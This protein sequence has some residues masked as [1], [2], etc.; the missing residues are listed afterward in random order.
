MHGVYPRQWKIFNWTPL[1]KKGSK[2]NR[3]NYRPISLLNNLAKILDKIV[4]K[5]LYN[6]CDK[7]KYLNKYNYGFKQKTSCQHNLAMLLHNTYKILDKGNEALII[8]FDVVKAFDKVDH[9]ILL[10][11]LYMLGINNT[12]HNWF[13]NYL[14]NRFSSVVINNYKSKKY[15][16]LSSVTQGSVF[17]TLLWSIYTY[18]ITEDIYTL[19]SIFADDTAL[20]TEIDQDI[21]Y[22]FGWMQNDIDTLQNWA[23]DNKL[24]FNTDKSVYM[25][26]SKKHKNEQNYPKIF[27]YGIELKRVRT[28]KQ[29]GIYIDELLTWTDHINYIQSKVFKILRMLKHIRKIITYEISEKIYK[30]IIK[31]I[32]DYGSM[33]YCNTTVANINKIEKLYYHSPLIVT[34]AYKN[35]NRLKLL[36]ELNW[37]TFIERSK[38]LSIIMFAKIKFTKIPKIIYDEFPFT[39]TLRHSDRFKNNLP[40]LI[41]KRNYFYNSYFVKMFRQWNVLSVDIKNTENYEDFKEK[42][43]LSQQKN[44]NNYEYETYTDTV[45]LSFRMKNSLLQSDKFKM[46][47]SDTTYA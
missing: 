21:E 6:Y 38:Y 42:L 14:S 12:E 3:E 33:F 19:P 11:K 41:S 15:P 7:N 8:F 9:L 5:T 46:G 28:Q 17:A 1:Y 22:S 18:D 24:S 36:Q 31:R 47:M 29:L 27:L 32:I 45:Y 30:S 35:T 37:D 34:K 44:Y 10:K 23:N 20:I 40:H 39:T 13:K 16:I 25:I 4:F 43:N 26:I 2:Y